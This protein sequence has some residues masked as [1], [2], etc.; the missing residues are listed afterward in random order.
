[1]GEGVAFSHVN[2]FF[3]DVRAVDDLSFAVEEGEFLV[4]VGPSGCGKTTALRM[5]AGL[6][7]PS[8]GE[9]SIAGRVVNSVAPRDRDIAMV[10]QSYALYPHMSVFDNL[11]FGLKQ[12][13]TPRDEIR[14]RVADAAAMLGLE[15]LLTRHPRELSGGQRQRVA[16]GRAIVRR[17]KVF[18]MDEP[19]SNLDAQLRL[20]TRAEIAALHRRLATTMIYVTHD[21]VEAMTMGTRIAVMKEG[22][23]QQIDTPRRLYDMPNNTF[24][25]T[26]IGS[27][28]MNLIEGSLQR[29]GEGVTF[30]GG[31]I[32]LDLGPAMAA[33]AGGAGSA[34]LGIRPEQFERKPVASAAGAISGEVQ[35]IEPM[36]SDLFVTVAPGDGGERPPIVARLDPAT[37]ARLGER[38]SL[39]PILDAAHLFDAVSGLRR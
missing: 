3:G 26:F 4:L 5:V 1:M 35:L 6:E 38:L 17:P 20:R 2:K 19:L 18:L 12:R 22:V 25:A 31:G 32:T 24:V 7:R 13:K 10:F 28:S 36:G 8:S 39:R 16:L 37:P 29:V 30:A 11:A 33:R 34:I 23:L 15:P 27:P 9:I 21:Q 14:T